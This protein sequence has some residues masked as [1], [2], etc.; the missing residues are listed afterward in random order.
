MALFDDLRRNISI[1]FLS[2]NHIGG[3]KV[4]V[5]ASNAIDYLSYS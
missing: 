4:G 1:I 5:L 3:A 2:M